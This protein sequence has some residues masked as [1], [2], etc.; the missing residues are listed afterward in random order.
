MLDLQTQPFGIEEKD[1]EILRQCFPNPLHSG[2]LQVRGH[3]LI[4]LA[5]RGTYL[6]CKKLTTVL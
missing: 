5:H 3:T 1:P 4:T 2:K 6:V